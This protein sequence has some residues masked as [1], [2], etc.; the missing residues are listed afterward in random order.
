MGQMHLL[1]LKIL[2]AVHSMLPS[3]EADL[4]RWGR[5]SCIGPGHEEVAGLLGQLHHLSI[6]LVA[7]VAH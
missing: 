3:A 1:V 4:E 2:E 6:G 5:C 7:Q